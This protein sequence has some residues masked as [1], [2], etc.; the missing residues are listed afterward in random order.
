MSNSERADGEVERTRWTFHRPDGCGT[1][2]WKVLRPVGTACE[3]AMTTWSSQ[4]LQCELHP[5]ICSIY[6]LSTPL[7]MPLLPSSHISRSREV[8]MEIVVHAQS[9]FV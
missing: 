3:W 8:L 1:C 5:I 4:M 7:S 6:S 9:T 2:T